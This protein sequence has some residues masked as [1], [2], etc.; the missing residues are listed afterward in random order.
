M[1]SSVEVKKKYRDLLFGLPNVTGLGVGRKMV[2]GRETGE[3]ALIV[4]VSSKVP[5]ARLEKTERI[6]R[7]L[8][9]VPLDVQVQAPLSARS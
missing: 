2:G 5:D 4:F 9:G 7:E 6:P 8:D 3:L 1:Q